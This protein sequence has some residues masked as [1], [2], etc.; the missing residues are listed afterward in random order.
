M[1][2]GSGDDLAR[3]LDSA[4]DAELIERTA[5]LERGLL[6]LEEADSAN[7]AALAFDTLHAT[8]YN[9]QGAARV[10][11]LTDVAHL[12]GALVAA[13]DAAR[14]PDVPLSAAWFAAARR[15]IGA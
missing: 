5:S 12:A 8:T 11:D 13:L 3:Q 2:M 15:A 7:T 1:A 6:A 10:A 4:F 14:Q 9:L